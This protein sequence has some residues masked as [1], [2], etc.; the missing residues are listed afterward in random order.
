MIAGC[1]YKVQKDLSKELTKI[2]K[3][4]FAQ[5]EEWVLFIMHN[6]EHNK[7]ETERGPEHLCKINP[8]G[9]KLALDIHNTNTTAKTW[10]ASVE[11]P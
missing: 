3:T 9:S 1:F 2:L 7:S 8:Q 4:C 10:V 5:Q 11:L 6:H